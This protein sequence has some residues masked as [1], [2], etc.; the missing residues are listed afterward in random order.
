LSELEIIPVEGASSSRQFLEFPYSLYCGDTHWVPPLR[1]AQKELFDTARHPFYATASMHRLLARR[2]GEVVGRIA[3]I[4]NRNHNEYHGENAGFF[5]FFESIDDQA[6]SAGLFEAARSWLQGQGAEVIR[7]PV[8]PSTNYECG[9]LVDGFDSPPQ[10]MMPYNP[11]Y[12][13]GL[14]QAAGL[15]KAKDLY[16]YHM[17]TDAMLAQRVERVADRSARSNGL[18]IR[19]IRMDAFREDVEQ[20]WEVYNAAWSRNWGFVPVTRDEFLTMAKEMKAILDPGFVLI[21]E[22]DGRVVGF[23]L[24]LPDINQALKHARGRLFPFGLLKILYH[25]RF[26]RSVR[27]LVLGVVEQFRTAGVAAGFYAELVRHARRRGFTDCE[28]SWVL[29]DN[30]LM[31]RSIEAFGGKHYKTYR[32]Y[33]WN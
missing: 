16:A 7:G 5:G 12:Y 22:V 14:I 33:E 15:R 26:I 21:G 3:A 30:T 25:K 11:R 27:V 13:D 24:G 29:E 2:N 4:L 9:L 18:R 28:M 8:N 32:I 20:V 31:N 17:F 1:I 19:P 6:V 23:A 10:V